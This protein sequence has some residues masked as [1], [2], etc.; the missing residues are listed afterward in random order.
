MGFV[1]GFESNAIESV[2]SNA[3]NIHCCVQTLEIRGVDLR[4]ANC[5]IQ[6]TVLRY[7]EA[8]ISE[9]LSGRG[10]VFDHSASSMTGIQYVGLNNETNK[11]RLDEVWLD[12]L[13]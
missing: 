3:A 5:H 7:H 8:A 4:E 1:R 13:V 11:C 10:F 9:G 2:A 12:T 6:S